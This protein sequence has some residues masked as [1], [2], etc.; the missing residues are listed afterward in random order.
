MMIMT[1]EGKISVEGQ[2]IWKN[3]KCRNFFL[4]A[5]LN[6]IDICKLFLEIVYIIFI[7]IIYIVD[8]I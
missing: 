7:V 5:M 8:K 4:K 1:L 3:N 6:V 2:M